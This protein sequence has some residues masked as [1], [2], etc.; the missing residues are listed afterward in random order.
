[1]KTLKIVEE[2]GYMLAEE[3]RED[4]ALQPIDLD[5]LAVCQ[6]VA[7]YKQLDYN[8][9]GWFILPLAKNDKIKTTSL[10][11]YLKKWGVSV[12]DDTVRRSVTKLRYLGYL[13]YKKGCYY[14]VSKGQLSEIKILKGTNPMLLQS[15]DNLTSGNPVDCGDIAVTIDT[16]PDAKTNTD[17]DSKT[18]P[19]TEWEHKVAMERLDNL[20]ELRERAIQ[21]VLEDEH[22]T[23]KWHYLLEIIKQHPKGYYQEF[24]I[25]RAKEVLERVRQYEED[26]VELQIYQS[27][28]E[29][30]NDMFTCTPNELY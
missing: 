12:S 17:T 26:E 16:E 30:L 13:D 18:N 4:K 7:N 10:Q 8:K 22:N 24:A 5:V 1:M 25:S 23:G 19:Y 21:A 20:S 14:G 27:W 6:Y 9:D 11:E 28:E 3:T 29:D 2:A 15:E